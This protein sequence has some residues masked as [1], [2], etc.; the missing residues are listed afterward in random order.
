MRFSSPFAADYHTA[1]ANF[2][3]AAAQRDLLCTTFAHPA[4]P[5]L[6]TDLVWHGARDARHILL[7]TS[8]LH[9]IE[10][11][12]GSAL[13]TDDLRHAP[14]PA[15]ASA[16]IYV[17][18]LNPYGFAYNRRVNEDNIDLNRN[19]LDWSQALPPA[20]PL[21]AQAQAALDPARWHWPAMLSRGIYLAA[22]HGMNN[23]QAALQ[24]GQYSHPAGLFYGGTAPA[25]S[26]HLIRRI[27][28]SC[29]AQASRLIHIDI[30]TGLG[31]RGACEIIVNEES[32]SARALWGDRVKAINSGHSVSTRTHGDI[33]NA[34]N[35]AARKDCEILSV[36]AEFGTRS[37]IAVLRAL[38][39]DNYAHA[40]NDNASERQQA[41]RL[42]RAAFAPQDPAWEKNVLERG[43]TV[44]AQARARL[45][46]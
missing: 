26:N 45:Q 1:R 41:A 28:T 4:F 43:R 30:H 44:I 24:G 8:G 2:R 15:P 12:A 33:T 25:W 5:D 40:Q 38:A 14:P 10:G 9:G 46:R 32:A 29:T 16:V 18:A 19:F 36:A 20:H 42:M 31:A 23:L 27:A 21:T 17:H 37:R 39:F 35:Q 34:F 13:Q 22:R 3:A 6:S 7:L 11:F